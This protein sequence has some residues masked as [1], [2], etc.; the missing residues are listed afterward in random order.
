MKTQL[1][2]IVSQNNNL[3]DLHHDTNAEY[4]LISIL[5]P[6]FNMGEFIAQA[7]NSVL[8][9]E[10][11]HF[12]IIVLDD[13]S[14]DNTN[15]VVQQFISP[16]HSNYDGRVK[17]ERKANGGKSSAINLGLTIYT[18]DYFMV[19]DADDELTKSSLQCRA[20]SA[21][22]LVNSKSMIIGGFEVFEIDET[23]GVR[24][25][26]QNAN[27][28]TLIRLFYFSLKTPFHA[29][30]CLLSRNLVDAVGPFDEKL[31]RCQDIDYSIRCLQKTDELETCESIVYRYRKHRSSQADRIRFRL[32]TT[33][34]RTHVFRKNFNGPKKIVIVIGG[35]IVDMVK[36][37][38]ELFGNFKR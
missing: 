5:I 33:K 11:K 16:A 1:I 26:L 12:E 9:G 32:R 18:G 37:G 10:Y 25:V 35:V 19:L 28:K 27:A 21:R 29:N 2:Q 24:S 13:G 23:V 8:S 20:D 14:T 3:S 6:V 7:I 38:F 22:A 34:H 31:I 15:E 17:Y 36:L 4:P 30:S